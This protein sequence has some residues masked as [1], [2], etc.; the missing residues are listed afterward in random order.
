MTKE[1]FI[2]KNQELLQR[3]AELEKAVMDSDW[4]SLETSLQ[5]KYFLKML[6]SLPHPIYVIDAHDYTISFALPQLAQDKADRSNLCFKVIYNEDRSCA[7]ADKLCI[8]EEIKKTKKNA[9]TEHVHFSKEGMRKFEVYGYPILDRDGNVSHVAVYPIEITKRNKAE[10]EAELNKAKYVNVFNSASDGIV[11][12]DKSGA[13]RDA[14]PQMCAMF[15]Y[16]LEEILKIQGNE[17]IMPEYRHLLKNIL[18][19]I[20][21]RGEFFTEMLGF[22]KDGST[23]NLEVKGSIFVDNETRKMLVIMR[24]VTERKRAEQELL[25]NQTRYRIIFNAVTDGLLVVEAGGQILDANPRVCEMFG[26]THE[27]ILSLHGK[28]LAPPSS[29]SAFAN[30]KAEI[31]EKGGFSLETTGLRK[32]GSEFD[33]EVFGTSFVFN[34]KMQ[35]LGIYRDITERKATEKALKSREDDLVSRTLSLE[36]ANAAL[37]VL[38]KRRDEDRR[39]FEEMLMINLRELVFPHLEALKEFQLDKAQRRALENLESNL[40]NIVSPFLQDLKLQFHGLSHAEIKVATLVKEG[41]RSKE[42]AE[43]MG[44]SK[45]TVDFYRYN[46]RKKLSMN[47]STHLYSFLSTINRST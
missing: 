7:D 16:S 21:T 32:D 5:N 30:I 29:H 36:E 34:D 19:D 13:I 10:V 27:E 6:N 39:E 43:I 38:L 33:L 28:V 18:S 35:M 12:V 45:R 22:R 44:L 37:K 42:I 23:F 20:K 9:V 2:E 17:L 26:Y 1:H 8:L 15:G 47:N 41:K 4:T 25:L 14:N 31:E 24:D 3:N 46:I 40:N 11:I